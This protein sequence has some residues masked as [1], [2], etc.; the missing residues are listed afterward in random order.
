M[1]SDS[2]TVIYVLNNQIGQEEQYN[3]NN[4]IKK[5]NHLKSFTLDMSDP[6]VC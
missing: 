4:L 2:D 3:S 6:C 5:F 1:N